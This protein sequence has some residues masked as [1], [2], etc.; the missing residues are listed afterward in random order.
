M[1]LT[2]KADEDVN[3][4]KVSLSAGPFP[5]QQCLLTSSSSACRAWDSL[6]TGTLQN[7]QLVSL[8]HLYTH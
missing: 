1:R 2:W 3:D 4:V 6:I 7:T 8:T 5:Q